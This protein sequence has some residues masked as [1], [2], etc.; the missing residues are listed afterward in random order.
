MAPPVLKRL[1]VQAQ[2]MAALLVYQTKMIKAHLANNRLPVEQPVLKRQTVRE[3]ETAV[4][5]VYLMLMGLDH[6]AKPL[7]LVDQR[8]PETT[9]VL[10]LE[11]HLAR[12]VLTA[13]QIQLANK[14]VSQ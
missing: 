13:D 2:E 4:L 5:P 3:L 9:N 8:V 7:H 14:F 11:T 1:I 10:E 12:H 6:P